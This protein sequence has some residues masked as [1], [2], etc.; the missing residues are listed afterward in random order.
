M[1]FSILGNLVFSLRCYR[2]AWKNSR[3][4]KVR[5]VSNLTSVTKSTP[6][7]GSGG[8]NSLGFSGDGSYLRGTGPGGST[9]FS[10]PWIAVYKLLRRATSFNEGIL[11]RRHPRSFVT[12]RLNLLSAALRYFYKCSCTDL[13]FVLWKIEGCSRWQ[14]AIEGDKRR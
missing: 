10:P 2:I 12:T 7:L 9:I 14:K 8:S 3:E 1:Y 11:F 13:V 4:I 5:E 6:G